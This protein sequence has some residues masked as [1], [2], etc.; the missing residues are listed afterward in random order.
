M[1]WRL[2]LAA[3][4]G[5]WSNLDSILH[6]LIFSMLFALGPLS[7]ATAQT[8]DADVNAVR[9]CVA[10]IEQQNQCGRFVSVTNVKQ[11]DRRVTP[12]S[13]TVIE[14]I[15]LDVL[16]PFFGQS[17]AAY[18]CTGWGWTMN[19]A[20]VRATDGLGGRFFLVGQKLK[21]QATFEFQ[22]FESGWRCAANRLAVTDAYYMNNQPSAADLASKP[23][24]APICAGDNIRCGDR[25]FNPNSGQ[26]CNN[27]NV[28]CTPVGKRNLLCF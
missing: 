5:R 25:C 16:E 14:E 17:A 21:V 27:G 28:V 18:N 11:V 2:C 19:P 3:N 8:P 12:G 6:P 9:Q 4:V 15:S 13:A 10:V 26:A 24:P 22:K 7:V 23:R 1:S 20:Q